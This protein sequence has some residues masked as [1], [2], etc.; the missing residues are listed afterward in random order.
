[1]N[2]S[3]AAVRNMSYRE[4]THFFPEICHHLVGF[5]GVLSYEFL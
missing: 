1:M 3:R 5:T 4:Y 2:T